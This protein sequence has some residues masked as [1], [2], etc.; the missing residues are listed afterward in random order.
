MV[1]ATKLAMFTAALV[2]AVVA[3]WGLGQLTGPVPFLPPSPSELAPFA[4]Y[5]DP[6]PHTPLEHG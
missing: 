3:G 5:L 6:V 4:P 2:L 1:V